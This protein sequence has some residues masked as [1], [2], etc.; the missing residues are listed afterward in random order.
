MSVLTIG[1]SYAALILHGHKD[2]DIRTRKTA[3]VWI[4]QPSSGAGDDSIRTC[5]NFLKPNWKVRSLATSCAKG[6]RSDSHLDGATAR[7]IARPDRHPVLPR[8]AV[9]RM[10]PADCYRPI[11]HP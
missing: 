3:A 11:A 10:I 9:S 5:S 4:E 6:G 8:G 1:P 2:M 7:R